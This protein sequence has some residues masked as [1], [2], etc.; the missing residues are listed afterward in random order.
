[1]RPAFPRTSCHGRRVRG[2]SVT[3]KADFKTR[4]D[5]LPGFGL[6]R[7]R[8]IRHFSSASGFIPGRPC[9]RLDGMMVG[10]GGGGQKPLM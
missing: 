7:R 1:M 5:D 4:Y 2:A 8:L 6:R 3:R 9:S 10:D